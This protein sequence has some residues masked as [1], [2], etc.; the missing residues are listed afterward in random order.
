MEAGKSYNRDWAVSGA[1]EGGTSALLARLIAIIEEC[2]TPDPSRR[3]T[4][5]HLLEKLAALKRE[6][7]PTGS[8]DGDRTV[9]PSESPLPAASTAV[10][11]VV[12]IVSAMEALS[13]DTSAVIDAIGGR[14]FS[15]FDALRTTAGVSFVNI[16]AVKRE[17]NAQATAGSS[18]GTTC[19]TQA[20]VC[21]SPTRCRVH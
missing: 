3:L 5:Q 14:T 1:K 8:G 17:L 12:A 21:A 13:L 15:T 7:T 20:E 18:S 6:G 2:V 16:M 11:D 19:S 4:V 10:Y 9:S